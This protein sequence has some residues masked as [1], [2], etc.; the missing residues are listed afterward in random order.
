MKLV[1]DDAVSADRE[2]ALHELAVLQSEHS[3][4]SSGRLRAAVLGAND[5]LVSNVSLVMGMAGAA[6]VSGIVLLAGL[7]GVVAGALSMALGEYVSVQTQRESFEALIAMEKREIARNPRHEEH[8]VTVIY[9]AKGIPPQEA[10]RFAAHIMRDPE[11][12]LDLM[13]RE[14]LGLNPDELGAPVAVALSS[15]AAFASGAIV[16]VIPFMFL[17]VATA[18]PVAAIL[19][20][21]A[22]LL[23]GG[24]TARMIGRS[25][26]HGAIRLALLGGAAALITH[27]AGRIAG[28]IANIA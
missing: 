11:V 8:E 7:A 6:P 1:N 14:E 24:F 22:L 23:T 19:T 17:P 28:G 10:A 18:A 12:A 27:V 9:R 4:D 25:P 13:A 3:V 26:L 16:P 21:L 2:S 15:M 20:V 5:G